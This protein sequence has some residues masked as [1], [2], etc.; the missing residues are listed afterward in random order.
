MKLDHQW[1]TIGEATF[2]HDVIINNNYYSHVDTHNH[3]NIIIMSLSHR[4]FVRL[5]MAKIFAEEPP[6]A[7]ASN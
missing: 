6:T 2:T 3:S 5:D 7:A 4:A 1:P